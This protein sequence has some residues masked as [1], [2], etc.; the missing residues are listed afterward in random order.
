MSY[1]NGAMLAAL[2]TSL[3]ETIGEVRNWDYRF[4]WLRDASMSIE[5]MFR[6]GSRR[7]AARRFMKFIQ[8]TLYRRA[9]TLSR[10]CTASAASGTLTETIARPPARATP[11]SQPRTHRQ[12]RLPPAAERLVRLPHGPD[13]PI[14][15]ADARHARR[16]RG[17]VG[18][19]Q[20]HSGQRYRRTGATP[21]RAS[22]RSGAKE[23]PLR[24]LEGHVLG[25]ARPRGA[26][27]PAMLRKHACAE[28]LAA[29]RPRRIRRDV[30]ETRLEG[31][32]CRAF[33]RAYG[34][35]GPRLRRCCLWNLTAFWMRTTY[36]I[37][38]RSR[39]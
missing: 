20:E 28:A 31:G 3:P 38:K 37:I 14:L 26:A 22:G 19:G 16:D 1:Y 9:T 17:H 15:P 2:T 36:A 8:S 34:N 12:R 29:R 33:P 11:G 6:S 39:P 25:G 27:S 7:R 32:D 10:S 24:L 13:L 23:Q 5:T 30:L 21:T 35:T 18:A 4:C